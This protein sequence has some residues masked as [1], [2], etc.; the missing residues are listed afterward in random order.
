[1]PSRP[2]GLII[3]RMGARLLAGE[4]EDVAAFEPA[5]LKPFVSGGA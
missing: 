1:M 5:Y 2:S 3:A 4:A